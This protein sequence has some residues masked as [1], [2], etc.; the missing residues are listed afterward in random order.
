MSTVTGTI[1]LICG[2]RAAAEALQKH[3]LTAQ[4]TSFRTWA[5]DRLAAQHGLPRD[6]FETKE[7]LQAIV[8]RSCCF[9]QTAE[10][11]LHAFLLEAKRQHG[12][13]IFATHVADEISARKC[14]FTLPWIIYDWSTEAEA[15]VIQKR[16]PAKKIITIRVRNAISPSTELDSD[17]YCMFDCMATDGDMDEKF[18]G[19]LTRHDEV[20][21]FRVLVAWKTTGV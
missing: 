12:E 20:R 13:E 11:V 14:A 6:L 1:Y 19:L 7:G 3:V 15:L 8:S 21:G 5:I 17:R 9:P 10:Q 4:V 2:D 16:F 18:R